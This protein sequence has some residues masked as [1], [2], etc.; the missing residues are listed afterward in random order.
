M[1][2]M[3]E[4]IAA[5]PPLHGG[6]ASTTRIADWTALH[7]L[8]ADEVAR[9]ESVLSDYPTAEI[10]AELD[11]ELRC[12]FNARKLATMPELS[13]ADIA[14]ARDAFRSGRT[15]FTPQDVD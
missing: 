14:R 7:A 3:P 6:G 15:P 5:E 1:A 10:D 9:L 12:I 11:E 4:V 13:R 8:T 2:T